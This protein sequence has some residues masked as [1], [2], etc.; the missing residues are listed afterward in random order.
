M[1]LRAETEHNYLLATVLN[2]EPWACKL[3]YLNNILS[4]MNE[5][6]RK[7][8]QLLMQTA[9]FL[10]KEIMYHLECMEKKESGIFPHKKCRCMSKFCKILLNT[11]SAAQDKAVDDFSSFLMCSA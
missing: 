7:N 3:V 9:V 8:S 4:K 6:Q 1:E 11:I 2:S 10:S 5:M